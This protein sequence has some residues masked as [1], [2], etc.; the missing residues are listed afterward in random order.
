MYNSSLNVDCLFL[1]FVIKILSGIC[2]LPTTLFCA[3]T[4]IHIVPMSRSKTCCH[5][6]HIYYNIC[7]IVHHHHYQTIMIPSCL[8]EQWLSTSRILKTPMASMS[9]PSRLTALTLR[10]LSLSQKWSESSFHFIFTTSTLLY[11]I[12]QVIWV[13]KYR[14]ST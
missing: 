12:S 1:I 4:N 3:G 10:L 8:H 13:S 7:S 5:C 9:L 2:A 14:W 11:H 6:I